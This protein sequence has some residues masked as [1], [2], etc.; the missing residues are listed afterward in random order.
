VLVSLPPGSA[1]SDTFTVPANTTP[2][3]Y[4]IVKHFHAAGADDEIAVE[5]DVVAKRP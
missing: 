4:R 3:R 1:L 2:G 5:V